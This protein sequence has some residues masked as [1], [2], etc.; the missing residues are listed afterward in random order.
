ML[1]KFG[2]YV[3]IMLLTCVI[4]KRNYPALRVSPERRLRLAP[5]WAGW[6]VASIGAGLLKRWSVIR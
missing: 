3:L 2:K 6:L 1:Y 5:I 4:L